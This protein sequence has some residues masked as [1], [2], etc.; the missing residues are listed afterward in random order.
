VWHF[1]GHAS[2]Q[3]R[4]FAC[5]QPLMHSSWKACAQGNANLVSCLYMLSLH[6]TQK[7]HIS[8]G[9]IHDWT[10]EFVL[11]PSC[12]FSEVPRLPG[13][14]TNKCDIFKCLYFNFLRI[15]SRVRL[16]S[17][18]CTRGATLGRQ[19]GGNGCWKA[20]TENAGFV[21]YCFICL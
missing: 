17:R 5:I 1:I 16:G 19:A 7:P 2:S 18:E 4:F 12:Q 13:R 9:T 8:D 10:F 3:E 6:N 11:L 15:L 14:R 20:Q 21:K